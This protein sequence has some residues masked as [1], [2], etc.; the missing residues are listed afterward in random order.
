MC[1]KK[2]FA[3]CKRGRNCYWKIEINIE[4][5][6]FAVASIDYHTLGALRE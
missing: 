4:L 6:L 5:L 3:G 1:V 2:Q